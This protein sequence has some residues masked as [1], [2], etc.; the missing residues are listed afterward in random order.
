MNARD[1]GVPPQ[2]TLRCTA[3]LFYFFA[4]MACALNHSTNEHPVHL[5]GLLTG[6]S[7]HLQISQIHVSIKMNCYHSGD[8][9]RWTPVKTS[10]FQSYL[11]ITITVNRT[12]SPLASVVLLLLQKEEGGGVIW[13]AVVWGSH[14]SSVCYLQ[15]IWISA[16]PIW[17][18]SDALLCTGPAE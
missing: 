16:L 5:R 8:A 9:F 1:S 13:C 15:Y 14:A 18:Q 4:N 7:W 6:L 17:R 2:T 10:S 12:P 11:F 3:V